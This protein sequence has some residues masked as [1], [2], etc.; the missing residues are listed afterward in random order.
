VYGITLGRKL[1]END[2]SCLGGVANWRR[3]SLAGLGA[4]PLREATTAALR[5][6]G[7]GAIAAA[8]RQ[9]ACL[10]ARGEP[11]GSREE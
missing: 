8:G 2:G 6:R 5:R 7:H 1:A 3:S 11:E 9:P 10:P 4:W